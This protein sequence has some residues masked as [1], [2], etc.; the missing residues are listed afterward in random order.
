MGLAASLMAFSCGAA[1]PLGTEHGRVRSGYKGTPLSL[2]GVGEGR[3]GHGGSERSRKHRV[4]A[5]ENLWRISLHYQTSVEALLAANGIE[6]VTQLQVGQELVIPGSAIGDSDKVS[7]EVTSRSTSDVRHAK[8]SNNGHSYRLDW[9]VQGKITSRYGRRWGRAHDGI[10]IGAPQ[11]TPVRAAD[12]GEVLYSSRHGSYGNLVLVRHSDDLV[13]V[14]AHH[15]INLVRKGQQV[16]R[17]QL[18]A[19]V[20]QS[21]RATG[22]HLHFEVRRGAQPDNPLRYLPP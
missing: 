3:R 4:L 17:G 13:T 22:P 9:P 12:D 14:Y 16:S 6:D 21:G 7:Q 8:L 20:G 19:K 10:D 18:I 11:G 15:K 1:M 5:G 2:A